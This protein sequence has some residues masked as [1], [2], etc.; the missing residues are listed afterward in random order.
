MDANRCMGKK[1]QGAGS[2]T[3][4]RRI[5]C[6]G[7]RPF[8]LNPL[9]FSPFVTQVEALAKN[10]NNALA[11]QACGYPLYA[12]RPFTLSRKKD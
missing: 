5:P 9:S 4:F 7:N 12:L 6:S 3:V 10:C 11:G 1:A 8:T 2:K